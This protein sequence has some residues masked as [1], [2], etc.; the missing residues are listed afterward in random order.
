MDTVSQSIDNLGAT[1]GNGW[2]RPALTTQNIQ[3]A[4]LNIENQLRG[5]P[6]ESA[7]QSQIVDAYK[8]AN[9]PVPFPVIDYDLIEERLH[10]ELDMLKSALKSGQP[11]PGAMIDIQL[12]GREVYIVGDLH[13]NEGGLNKILNTP[14]A[15]G[16]TLLQ[17][18][19]ANK[20]VVVFEGDAIHPPTAPYDEM[21]PSIKTLDEIFK[22]Q[23]QHPD[24]VFY[25]RGNHDAVYGASEEKFGKGGTSFADCTIQGVEFREDLISQRRVAGARSTQLYFDRSPLIIRVIGDGKVISIN[26]H[27]AVVMGGITPEQAIAASYDPLFANQLTW[28]RPDGSYGATDVRAMQTK[29]GSGAETGVLSGHTPHPTDSAASQYRPFSEV[30]NHVC[31]QASGDLPEI[32]VAVIKPDGAID[33]VKLTGIHEASSSWVYDYNI[34]SASIQPQACA[35]STVSTAPGVSAAD[36]VYVVEPA[37]SQQPRASVELGVVMIPQEDGGMA[38]RTVM[39]GQ[40]TI[41][42]VPDGQ[43]VVFGANNS[44][45]LFKGGDGKIYVQSNGGSTSIVQEITSRGVQVGEFMLSTQGG[46]D[47]MITRLRNPAS[48]AGAV[49]HYAGLADT[50]TLGRAW[51]AFLMGDDTAVAR[52][53]EFR[54]A[55]ESNVHPNETL[56]NAGFMVSVA[57]ASV[58]IENF[59]KERGI[60]LG[61]LGRTSLHNSLFGLAVYAAERAAG[62]MPTMESFLVGYGSFLPAAVAGGAPIAWGLNYVMSDLGFDPR[63]LESQFVVATG[64]GL[65]IALIT[66]ATLPA[67]TLLLAGGATTIGEMIAGGA[68]LKAGALAAGAGLA[69]TAAFLAGYGI[70]RAIDSKL[71][72][73]GKGADWLIEHNYQPCNPFTSLSCADGTIAAPFTIAADA[74]SDI[75]N[76]IWD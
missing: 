18:I 38:I 7:Q 15:N 69:V 71:N 33:M 51:D 26:A 45:R 55:R 34:R 46:S 60:E 52:P 5:I 39:P 42:T 67:E 10:Y 13:G 1:S 12:N 31:L 63:S 20:A 29:L 66:S 74:A 70:G 2:E 36:V 61:E 57:G 47:V 9:V 41:F 62:A 50:E 64:T 75:W 35:V 65:G 72:I 23:N 30:P 8:S 14:D 40:A 32:S 22:L 58:I 16:E 11:V 43:E 49:A 24:N 6:A 76:W 37:D 53:E 3:E 44:N 54:A 73:S 21:G 56:G 59:L 28:N 27:S 19:R 68:V 4:I 17:K 48:G 25:V